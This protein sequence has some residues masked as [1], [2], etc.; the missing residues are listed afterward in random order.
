MPVSFELNFVLLK[1]QTSPTSSFVL[2]HIV[3]RDSGAFLL[4]LINDFKKSALSYCKHNFFMFFVM[5]YT[6]IAQ[7]FAFFFDTFG[8]DFFQVCV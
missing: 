8:Y 1:Q 7:T 6:E 4:R 5:S 3:Q 2:L